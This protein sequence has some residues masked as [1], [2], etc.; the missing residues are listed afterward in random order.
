MSPTIFN[1]VLENIFRQLDRDVNNI[2]GEKLHHLRFADDIIL[3]AENPYTPKL[4]LQLVSQ[5]KKA[6]LSM[7][8]S[9]ETND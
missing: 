5:I 8:T 3:F 6:R 7:N 1:T 9:S 2:N 4:I